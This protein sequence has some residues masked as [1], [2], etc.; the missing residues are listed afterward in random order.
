M[1]FDYEKYQNSQL[2]S[3]GFNPETLTED[4]KGIILQPSE[5]PENFYCDGEISHKE[6]L[7]WWIQKLKRS[8]LNQAQIKK[9]IKLN[10]G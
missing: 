9:A 7:A 10:F 6:A 2:K 1:A 4:Q 5:G 3:G 8:G